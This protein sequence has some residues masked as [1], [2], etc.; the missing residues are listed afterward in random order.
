MIS[1][2][3]FKT[4][5][6]SFKVTGKEGSTSFCRVSIP[7]AVMNGTLEVFVNGTETPFTLLPCSNSTASYLYFT[8]TFSTEQ[9]I[10]VPEFLSLLILPLL[11]IITLLGAMILRRK[12]SITRG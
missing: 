11:M 9:V 10:I 1:I 3:T 2:E 12:R 5:S 8:C 7:T 6:V 4:V